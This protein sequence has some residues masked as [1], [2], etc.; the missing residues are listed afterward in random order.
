MVASSVRERHTSAEKSCAESSTSRGGGAQPVQRRSRGREPAQ[1]L[2]AGH[3]ASHGLLAL[4][5]GHAAAEAAS[6]RLQQPARACARDA[7]L[8]QQLDALQ[9]ARPCCD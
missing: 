9:H 3:G 1:L 7:M 4:G 6:S 8:L 2:L 5:G